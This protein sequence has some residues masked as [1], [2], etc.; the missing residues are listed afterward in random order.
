MKRLKFPPPLSLSLSLCVCVCVCVSAFHV[1]LQPED[2]RLQTENSHQTPNK[3]AHWSWTCQPPELG[4]MNVCW[5]S[6]TVSSICCSSPSWVRGSLW[7]SCALSWDLDGWSS[8]CLGHCLD[9]N[10]R[11]TNHAM[12]LKISC[13]GDVCHFHSHSLD[14][15]MSWS[16]LFHHWVGERYVFHQKE[17]G[18]LG[19]T[20]IPSPGALCF[21]VY[22]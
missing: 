22:K 5:L 19:G 4:G 17:T 12:T 2:N 14:Q 21:S 7:A 13:R 15:S 9:E 11:M 1:R 3:L 16:E 10:G 8:L 18:Q 6:H 20:L